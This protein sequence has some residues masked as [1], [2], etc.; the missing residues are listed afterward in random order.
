MLI[1]SIICVL[2]L[3]FFA[4]GLFGCWFE[5]ACIS[6]PMPK[7]RMYLVSSCL[8]NVWEGLTGKPF[9]KMSFGVLSPFVACVVPLSGPFLSFLSAETFVV[10]EICLESFLPGF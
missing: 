7:E 5:F 10:W 1:K 4:M 6:E 9:W 8:P 3:L 2:S